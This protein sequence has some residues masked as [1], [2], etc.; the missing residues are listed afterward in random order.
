[1]FDTPNSIQG[2]QIGDFDEN[3]YIDFLIT[4]VKSS[5]LYTVFYFNN[6]NLDFEL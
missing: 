6:K 2:L 3:G 1:M 5:Q 4:Y